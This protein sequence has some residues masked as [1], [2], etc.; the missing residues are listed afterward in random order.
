MKIWAVVVMSVLFGCVESLE[1]SETDPEDQETFDQ[2]SEPPGSG[3]PVQESPH[4][5]DC[6]AIEYDFKF[7]DNQEFQILLPSFCNEYYFE[8]GRPPENELLEQDPVEI[9]QPIET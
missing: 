7:H 4:Q 3:A 9:I 6:Y 5:D 1:E 8:T 2:V